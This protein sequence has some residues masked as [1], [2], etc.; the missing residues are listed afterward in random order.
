M[1]NRLLKN[2]RRVRLDDISTPPQYGWTT[3]SSSK[4]KIRY[5]R[6]TDISSKKIN[7]GKVP[8]CNDLPEDL[9]KFLLKENDIVIFF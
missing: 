6:T 4:G 7:W 2:W 9:E 5:L 3:K 8:Y 1:A